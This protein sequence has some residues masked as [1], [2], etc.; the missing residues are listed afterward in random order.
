MERIAI[1]DM[2]K[3]ITRRPTFLPFA[4]HVLRKHAKRR[5]V[6][7]PLMLAAGLGYALK[8]ISR[9]KIKEV[10]TKLVL[11]RANPQERLALIGHS[12]AGH[13]AKANL[14]EPALVQIAADREQGYRIVLATASYR[15][16]VEPI[17][18]L[19]GIDDVIATDLVGADSDKVKSRILGE[20]CY[21]PGKLRMV[22]AWFSR[23]GIA[24]DSAHIRFYSDHVSDRYCLEWAD[25]AYAVNPHPPLRR[26]AKARGWAVLDWLAKA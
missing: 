26:M 7:V 2:D 25:E 23:H 17:A 22:E 9:T 21:G 20:N 13:N 15:F 19:L 14:L 12:F 16:Y 5:S 1:Y 24:R 18:K 4:W 6:V 8:I 11:G 10:N 3:T